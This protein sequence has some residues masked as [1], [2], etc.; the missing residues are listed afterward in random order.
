MGSERSEMGEWA[1]TV[2]CDSVCGVD[3]GVQ[4]WRVDTM[5]RCRQELVTIT[6]PTVHPCLA[7]APPPQ[8]RLPTVRVWPASDA[9]RH[10]HVS[11][12]RIA[13]WTGRPRVA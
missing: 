2:V 5:C 1:V 4:W 12:Q 8:C 10:T 3:H 7:T 11:E 13:D 9:R 6:R